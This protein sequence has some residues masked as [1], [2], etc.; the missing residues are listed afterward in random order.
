[1][2]DE[3][4]LSELKSLKLGQELKRLNGVYNWAFSV[5]EYILEKCASPPYAVGVGNIDKPLFVIH[6]DYFSESP[7]PYKYS[8]RGLSIEKEGG[9][10][11]NLFFSK[12][13]ELD[14]ITILKALEDLGIDLSQATVFTGE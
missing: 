10:C 8:N 13:K 6:T 2:I 3:F 5:T 4:K 12:T 7:N 9:F 1:M 14:E 11:I